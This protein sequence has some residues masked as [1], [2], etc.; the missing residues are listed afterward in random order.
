MI[1][2][3]ITVENTEKGKSVSS[4]IGLEEFVRTPAEFIRFD[5]EALLRKMEREK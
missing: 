1:I 2:I 4:S 3:K 5:I